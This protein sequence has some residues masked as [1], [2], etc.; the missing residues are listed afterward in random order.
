VALGGLSA[1]A[2][3]N[4]KHRTDYS[5]PES[6]SNPSA[7]QSITG[8]PPEAVVITSPPPTATPTSTG[9]AEPTTT[10]TPTTT[11]SPTP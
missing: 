1:C 11:G 10:T 9:T 6:G 4:P 7:A 5:T 3:G 2:E 8:A